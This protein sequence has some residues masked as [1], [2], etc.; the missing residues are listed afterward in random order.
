MASVD[1]KN[2]RVVERMLSYQRPYDSQCNLQV[3]RS[4]QAQALLAPRIRM[5]SWCL[6]T[7]FFSL[8]FKGPKIGCGV[9]ESAESASR[10]SK[11]QEEALGEQDFLLSV[12]TCEIWGGSLLGV[13]GK[14][15]PAR[16][17]GRII[18][19]RKRGCSCQK[20]EKRCGVDNMTCVSRSEWQ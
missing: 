5:M 15:L 10:L 14:P 20:K 17:G 18:T 9:G 13:L 12:S 7:Y 4:S 16:S 6:S 1:W 11:P 2:V 8:T 19:S 3:Q